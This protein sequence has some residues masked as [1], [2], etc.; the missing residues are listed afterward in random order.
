VLSDPQGAEQPGH[1]MAEIGKPPLRRRY[2]CSLTSAVATLL[3]FVFVHCSMK[4]TDWTS[5]V[6]TAEDEEHHH[7][8]HHY[9]HHHHHLD[10]GQPEDGVSEQRVRFRRGKERRL[11]DTTRPMP[12]SVRVQLDQA[13]MYFANSIRVPAAL[14][15]SQAGNM[16]FRLTEP[17]HVSR[18][19]V[20]AAGAPPSSMSIRIY[21]YI[22]LWRLHVMLTAYTVCA[23]LTAV[24]ICST[25]HAQILDIGRDDVALE[26]TALDLIIRHVEFEYVSV[27]ICYFS[28]LVSFLLAI[29]ARASATLGA[30]PK[31]SSLTGR[32]ECQLCIALGFMLISTLSW[33]L[34]VYNEDVTNFTGAWHLLRRFL[35]LVIRRTN[36]SP[37]AITSLF[38][39]GCS[40]ALSVYSLFS[41]TSPAP[42][43]A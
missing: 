10:E 17:P 20:S 25:A 32:R 2:S 1:A 13:T 39:A 41:I 24:L 31:G 14:I 23:E 26:P 36:N 19:A 18:S 5:E 37:L 33:W 22:I 11:R 30:G 6:F 43:V 29:A 28:G 12:D 9:H 35:R 21:I 16:L 34:H 27:R 8:H 38:C 15:A 42:A 40:I 3:C 4:W 7:H